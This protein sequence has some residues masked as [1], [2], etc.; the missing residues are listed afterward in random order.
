MSH[1]AIIFNRT[2]LRHHRDRAS[3]SIAHADFLF[4]E[5]AQLLADR[6]P[7]IKRH[8]PTVLDLGCHH[9]YL[10]DY[11]SSLNGIEW[12][13]Q[14][15]ISARMVSHAK[16]ARL[17]C[18][19]EFLPFADASFDLVTS[20]FSLQWI[21]DLPGTLIQIN[22]MLKP[23]GLMMV[24]LPG[25]Q[26]LKELRQSL[27]HA[28]LDLTGGLS[29]RISPFVDTRDGAGLLQRAGFTSPVADSEVLTI[30]YDSPQNLI[31]DLRSS[32]ETNNLL[33]SH[34]GGLCRSIFDAAMDYYQ[35]HFAH[36]NGKVNASCEVVTLTGW[37]KDA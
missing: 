12:I 33:A 6:L 28:E 25:G 23:G 24:M 35:E 30:H 17:V 11:I 9:G 5:C 26:T 3:A 4:R 34:T 27:E 14:A 37:K 31:D 15:D 18:D 32:G 21:N 2:R 20:V 16:G 13:V 22:R 36:A 29:P 1:P 10:R 8:F 19:E 7:D